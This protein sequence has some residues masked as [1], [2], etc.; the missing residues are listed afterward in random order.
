LLP[1]HTP[2]LQASVWVHLL[3]SLQPVPSG[4]LGLE[5]A[6]VVLSQVPATW[7]ASLGEH[8]TAPEPTHFPATQPSL[9]VQA[10]AS[11][12][13]VPSPLGVALQA[14]VLASHVPVLHGSSKAL[15]STAV[16]RLHVNVLK[17]QVSTPLQASLSTQSAFLVQPH[18]LVSKLQPV[19]STQLSSEQAILSSHANGAPTHTPLLHLS[20]LVQALPSPQGVSSGFLGLEQSPLAASQLP[21]LWHGSL[22]VQV[23]AP[24]PLQAPA[25]QVS[26]FVHALP[27]SHPVPSFAMG[28]EQ[29]PLLGSHLPAV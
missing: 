9:L 27:S 5:Q 17:S 25:R 23:T 1:V 28:L 29:A 20:P 26:V 24:P 11:S 19:G 10:L 6:P 15:Q 18:L 22:A 14:P 2:A 4:A 13:P 21:A 8:A 7:Q 12:Q 3:P 16:P